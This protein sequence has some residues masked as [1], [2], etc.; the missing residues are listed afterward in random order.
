MIRKLSHNEIDKEKRCSL[1]K[2]FAQTF[3]ID[4]VQDCINV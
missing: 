3:I 1:K 2:Y 4:V